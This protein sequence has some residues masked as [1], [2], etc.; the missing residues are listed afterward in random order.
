MHAARSLL[1][2]LVLS[3]AGRAAEPHPALPLAFVRNT[4]QFDPAVAFAAR[5]SGIAIAVASDGFAVQPAGVRFTFE[6]SDPRAQVEG[7][8][9]SAAHVNFLVGSPAEWRTDCPAFDAVAIRGLYPGIDL[10]LHVRGGIPEYDLLLDAGA[11]LERV[12]LRVEGAGEIA[13]DADGAWTGSTRAGRM[14]QHAPVA[15]AR[16][17]GGASDPIACETVHLG[18]GR[19]AFRCAAGGPILLDPGLEFATLLGGTPPTNSNLVA[20]GAMALAV[21]GDGEMVIAGYASDAGFPTTFGAFD[22]TYE[23]G[24][25]IVIGDA[26]VARFDA[27]GKTLR[28]ATF[29]GG[30]L[31]DQG[32]DVALDAAENVYVTGH[33]ASTTFPTSATFGTST[34]PGI[35]PFRTFISKLDPTGAVLIYSVVIEDAMPQAIA[36]DAGGAVYATGSAAGQNGV[37]GFPVTPGAA[38]TAYAGGYWDQF[39]LKLHPSGGSIVFA[40]LLGSAAV[41]NGLELALDGN[42]GTYVGGR[43][44][45]FGFPVSPGAFDKQYSSFAMEA[46]IAHVDASGSHV[47]AA[48]LLGGSHAT[49]VASIR[50]APDGDVVVAG[51]VATP[52]GGILPNPFPWTPGAFD[53]LYEGDAEGYVSI[54]DPQLKVLKAST[55]LGGPGTDS[56]GA[57]DVDAEGRIVAISGSDWGMVPV[58]PDAFQSTQQSNYGWSDTMVHVFTPD[59]SAIE[60]G[61]YL[62]G[63]K[64]DVAVDV[65]V[66]VPGLIYVAGRTGSSN[67]PATAGAFDKSLG[68]YADAFALRLEVC[69]GGSFFE[70]LGGGCAGTGGIAPELRGDGCPRSGSQARLRIAKGAPAAPALIVAGPAPGTIVVLPTCSLGLAS[71]FPGVLVPLALSVEG[72]AELTFAVPAVPSALDVWLQALVADPVANGGIAVT[73]ALRAHLQ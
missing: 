9:P 16:R 50:V 42:G 64:F 22:V 34:V 70:E 6:D 20:D 60:Y 52:D 66:P 18:N 2:L 23:T 37:T 45:S 71:L 4:G 8:D 38:S 53:T 72:G 44:G 68:G 49:E 47:L 29:L 5:S 28:F 12:V 57:M 58:T 46:T 15:T 48:T 1:A 32:Y 40:T 61:S 33:T 62:G 30:D 31:G 39:L 55:L 21:A 17:A 19:F 43:T 3:P 73:N 13:L 59:L 56:I 36:V 35:T 10:E 14:A 65:A 51:G 54:L 69:P 11:D 24:P 63:N 41:D 26:F 27:D 7:L 25:G 67:F